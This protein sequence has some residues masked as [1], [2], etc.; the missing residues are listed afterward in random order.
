MRVPSHSNLEFLRERFDGRPFRV[1]DAVAA[2]VSRTTL[3]RLRATGE[4]ATVGRGVVQL[5]DG[6]M[7]LLSEL[8]VVSARAPRGT[9]CL[10][11]ALA[12]WDLSDEIPEQVH[13]AVPRGM[14][15]PSIDQPATRVHV[16]DART[17]AIERQQAHT[18][19]DEPF[20]IYSP[21]RSVIDAMRMA[22]WV[23]RD[24]ALHALRRYIA[25]PRS[26]AARLAELARELGGSAQLRPALE[27]LLS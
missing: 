5:P 8:A 2:G 3:H 13:V 7:G 12:F 9:I 16:F 25:Q 15:R 27:A 4:L 26:D 10:N 20:W 22:R 19:A 1:S 18:D 17:F 23:G 11:S 24:T 6:G 21:E 14:H